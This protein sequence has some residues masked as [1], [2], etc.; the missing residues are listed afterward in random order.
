MRLC[1]LDSGLGRLTQA[2][3]HLLTWARRQHNTIQAGPDASLY[4]W[5][6]KT[7]NPAIAAVRPQRCTP[8]RS[9]ASSKLRPRSRCP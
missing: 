9:P 8:V 2:V 5:M 1:D 7:D 3:S 6:I 4:Q